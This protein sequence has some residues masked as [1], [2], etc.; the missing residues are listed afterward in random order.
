MKKRPFLLMELLIA[1]ALVTLFSF[2]LIR[3]PLLFFQRDIDCLARM[4]LERQAEVAFAEIKSELYNNQI[5]WEEIAK[6]KKEA[7]ARSL[8][9]I[10][11]SFGDLSKKTF[12]RKATLWTKKQKGELGKEEF[13]RVRVLITFH[14]TEK[15]KPS[16]PASFLYE[17]FV[18]RLQNINS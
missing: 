12:E 4:E 7:S 3:T 10:T 8:G 6:E 16:K 14:P 2:L 11:L 17:V 15:K 18:T 5:P 1:F 13:R 9:K